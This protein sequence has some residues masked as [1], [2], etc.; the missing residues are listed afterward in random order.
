VPPELSGAELSGTAW[1]TRAT[2]ERPASVAVSLRLAGSARS[3]TTKASSPGVAPMMRE[4]GEI[5]GQ[6]ES[7]ERDGRTA[8]YAREERAFFAQTTRVRPRTFLYGGP[9]SWDGVAINRCGEIGSS[10][11]K[12]AWL[13]T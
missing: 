7:G 6:R 1:I 11:W 3:R 13:Q 10:I 8:C 9:L 2:V 12:G 5:C 4:S